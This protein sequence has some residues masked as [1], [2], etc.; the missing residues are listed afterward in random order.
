MAKKYIVELSQSERNEL[1]NLIKIGKGGHEKITRAYILLRSDTGQWGEGWKD[2]QI[3]E[4][5]NVSLRKIERTRQRLVEEGFGSSLNRKVAISTRPRK[6][7]GDA[8]AHLIALCCG[9]PPTGQARWTL[10]LL[11]DKMVE[12]NYVDSITAE[13]IRKNL[14]KMNLSLGKRKN[15]AFLQKQMPS[16]SAKWKKS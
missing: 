11:A 5:Y 7:D 14:K 2:Q 13:G 16:L 15:G 12:L 10:Q 1:S 6:I 4:A 3:S 8:E 9:E